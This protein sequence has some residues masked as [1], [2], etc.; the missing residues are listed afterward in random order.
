MREEAKRVLGLLAS[1]NP[2][3]AANAM[4]EMANMATAAYSPAVSAPGGGGAYGGRFG[5][6]PVHESDEERQM[7]RALEESRRVAA[8]HEAQLA[9]QDADLRRALELSAHDAALDPRNYA[10][11][12]VP[13]VSGGGEHRRKRRYYWFALHS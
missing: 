7:A 11:S 10:S 6:T 2:K 8:Q 3:S 4:P 1:D 5:G 12:P 13:G 9:Q